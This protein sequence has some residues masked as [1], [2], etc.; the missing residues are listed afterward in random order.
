MI[1]LILLFIV[2]I[3]V[4]T[5][6]KIYQKDQYEKEIKIILQE[7]KSNSFVLFDESFKLFQNLKEL[8]YLLRG[9][10]N[11]KDE[12]KKICKSSV[13]LDLI[14]LDDINKTKNAA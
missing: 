5:A 12:I 13:K 9:K 11:R 8:I 14:E 3:A 4:L 2:L 10:N 1:T 6:M 7:I